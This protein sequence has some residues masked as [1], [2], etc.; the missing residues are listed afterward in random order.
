MTAEIK[1]FIYYQALIFE[2]LE[3]HGILRG[4]GHHMAQALASEAEKIFKGH[5]NFFR[6]R[7]KCD[8]GLHG[9]VYCDPYFTK[10]FEEPIE[11]TNLRS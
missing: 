8:C 10:L 3:L 4:N 11:Q 9:C 5:V 2:E 1:N 6:L 7:K